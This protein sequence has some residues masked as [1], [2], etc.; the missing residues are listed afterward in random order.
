MRTPSKMKRKDTTPDEHE[1]HVCSVLILASL[2]R[3]CGEDGRNR[4]L[5]KFSEHDYEKVDRAVELLL[6]YKERV[7][8]FD[9]RQASRSDSSKLSDE[10]LELQYL[11]RL[12]AGLYT[13]QRIALILADV[14][15]NANPLCRARAN[16]LLH[17]RT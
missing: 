11:D 13:L 7:D 14:C 4:V 8:R 12:D 2:L 1:E 17:M 9:A 3:S 6:K 10:E 15:A 5:M 16:R